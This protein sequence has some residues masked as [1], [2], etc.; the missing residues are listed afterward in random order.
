[1]K[2][3]HFAIKAISFV[4]AF[5]IALADVVYAAPIEHVGDA[6]AKHVSPS[7]A[8]LQDPA[9]FEAPLDFST[10]KEIHA[11]GKSTF[12]VHIQDAHANLSGQQNLAGALDE[13]MSKYKI[14][15]VLV[16]GGTR[17][18]SLTPIK[19]LATPDVWK[20]VAK[21]FLIEG[22]ITGE[23]YLNL[24]SDHPMKIMGIEDKAL[25]MESLNAYSALAE[26]REEALRSLKI[27]RNAAE[28]LK[29]KLYPAD[30]AEYEGLDREKFEDRFKVLAR[31]GRDPGPN[32]RKLLA[33]QERESQIDFKIANLEQAAL[34]EAISKKGG[35]EELKGL[36]AKLSKM[37][38]QKASQLNFLQ[39]LLRSAKE[40]NIPLEAYSNLFRYEAYLKDFSGIDLEALIE[41]ME[42]LEDEVYRARLTSE[43]ARLLRSIDRYLGLLDVAFRIQMS[44]KEFKTFE[45]NEPD[46]STVAYLAFLNRKLAEMGYFEDMLAAS[47]A[48]E[49]TK[50]VL[51]KFY[52]VVSRRDEAFLRNSE[53]ILKEEEQEIAVLIAGGYHTAHLR[54]LFKDKGF[55]YAVL[56]PIVRAETNQAKYEKILLEPIREEKSTVT[57]GSETPRS[58]D[59]ENDLIQLKKRSEGNRQQALVE[60]GSR[61]AE[62]IGYVSSGEEAAAVALEALTGSRLKDTGAISPEA[63]EKLRQE[64]GSRLAEETGEETFEHI[65]IQGG[66]AQ[67]A[68][69][70]KRAL[71]SIRDDNLTHPSHLR[72]VTRVIIEELE[73]GDYG[74]VRHLTPRI[75]WLDPKGLEDP[76]ALRSLLRHELAHVVEMTSIPARK[77]WKQ[78][79]IGDIPSVIRFFYKSL[80]SVFSTIG[81]SFVAYLVHLYWLMPNSY[82]AEAS[83]AVASISMVFVVSLLATAFLQPLMQIIYMTPLAPVVS[84][85]ALMSGEDFAESYMIYANSPEKFRR[86]AKF[87][88]FLKA[89]YQAVKKIHELDLEKASAST[90]SKAWNVTFDPK[91]GS[92]LAGIRKVSGPVELPDSPESR[93]RQFFGGSS[94]RLMGWLG[95]EKKNGPMLGY[96]VLPEQVTNFVFYRRIVEKHSLAFENGT[97][98]WFT[99]RY[100][101][102]IPGKF[103]LS[104]VRREALVTRRAFK[105]GLGPRAI[106]LGVQGRPVLVLMPQEGRPLVWPIDESKAAAVGRALGRLHSGGVHHGDLVGR[107]DTTSPRLD[108]IYEDEGT[109]RF[110]D[111]GEGDVRP[112]KASSLSA[113]WNRLWF[114][115]DSV[116]EA[117]FLGR[118]LGHSAIDGKAEYVLQA[119]KAAYRQFSRSASSAVP[120]RAK[121]PVKARFLTEDERDDLAA[122]Q[123]QNG[124][125]R[126][127]QEPKIDDTPVESTLIEEAALLRQPGQLESIVGVDVNGYLQFITR[128]TYDRWFGARLA[129]NLKRDGNTHAGAHFS[130]RIVRDEIL[131][132]DLVE[133]IPISPKA[134]DSVRLA[135]ENL[136][137]LAVPF[138][139]IGGAD[140]RIRMELVQ[141]LNEA[142]EERIARADM[143]SAKTLLRQFFEV[144]ID[145]IRRGIVNWDPKLEN[146]GLTK[147]GRVVL[148]DVDGLVSAESLLNQSSEELNSDDSDIFFFTTKLREGIPAVMRPHFYQFT[149]DYHL[150]NGSEIYKTIQRLAYSEKP[151]KVQAPAA[152]LAADRP[153][154]EEPSGSA[155][156]Q[157]DRLMS[158]VRRHFD[159]DTGYAYGTNS[160]DAGRGKITSFGHFRA[161][162]LATIEAAFSVIPIEG[163]TVFSLGSGQAPELAVAAAYGA[164]RAVGVEGDADLAEDAM[165]II[166]ALRREAEWADI[167][168]PIEL[169][170]GNF[171][172]DQFSFRKADII[173]YTN[174]GSFMETA[175]E[176]KLFDQ[177]KPEALLVL[178][179]APTRR[180]L[181]FFTK[182]KR[183]DIPGLPAGV[184]VYQNIGSRLAEEGDEAESGLINARDLPPAYER[185]FDGAVRIA[186]AF[187]RSGG[188]AL[189]LSGVTAPF[190]YSFFAVAW[191]RLFED[192]P[193]PLTYWIRPETE[194]FLY[195]DPVRK[196]LAGRQLDDDLAAAAVRTVERRARKETGSL[197]EALKRN[198]RDPQGFTLAEL[199]RAK[200]FFLGE[201]DTW[202]IEPK[203]YTAIFKALGFG[204]VAF[205]YH[206]AGPAFLKRL[207]SALAGIEDEKLARFMRSV[208]STLVYWDFD[209]P[210]EAEFLFEKLTEQA[211]ELLGHRELPFDLS[212][213]GDLNESEPDRDPKRF[214]AML[215]VRGYKLLRSFDRGGS[216]SSTYLAEDTQGRRV[217]IKYADWDGISGNGAPWVVRQAEKLLEIQRTFPEEARKQYPR[218]LD[219]GQ[220]KGE[221]FYAMELFE[222]AEDIT[223]Y[224]FFEPGLTQQEIAAEIDTFVTLMAET[225]YSQHLEVY[226]GEFKKHFADRLAMRLGHLSRHDGEI[227]EKLVRGRPAEA[228]GRQYKDLSYLFE[229]LLSRPWI[230]VNGRAY[231]NLPRLAA[232]LVERADE[233]E[234]R[235][236]PTHYSKYTH[237]DL[238]LRNVLRLPDGTKKIIDVRGRDIHPES[239]SQPSV[240]YD[241]AK[242]AH[243]FTLELVRNGY[244]DLRLEDREGIPSIRLHY[245][246]H[247]GNRRYLAMRHDFSGLLR[248][249]AVLGKV[250]ASASDG[251]LDYV[252]L[253][254]AVNYGSDAIHRLSQD[255]T[256]RDSL[257]Y[258]AEATVGI[259]DFL[260]RQGLLPQDW[261]LL[262][263]RQ[264]RSTHAP[265]A[266]GY[267]QIFEGSIGKEEIGGEFWVGVNG[268]GGSGKTEFTSRLVQWAKAQGRSLPR[269]WTRKTGETEFKPADPWLSFDWFLAERDVRNEV[270]RSAADGRLP[271]SR[272]RESAWDTPAFHVFL[273]NARQTSSAKGEA[274]PLSIEHA[275]NRE[276]G[277]RD[278]EVRIEFPQKA[279]IAVE[280]VDPADAQTRPIFDYVFFVDVADDRELVDRALARE[281]RKSPEKRLAPEI[282]QNRYTQVD[283][284]RAHYIRRVVAPLSDAIV[285]NTDYSQPVLYT[286]LGARLAD[287]YL[288]GPSDGRGI[289]NRFPM[290]R[291]L[292]DLAEREH[293]QVISDF[294]QGLAFVERLRK[295]DPEQADDLEQRASAVAYRRSDL[296]A[297]ASKKGLSAAELKEAFGL[298]PQYDHA[299]VLIHKD[300]WSAE[301]L[302]LEEVL[303]ILEGDN[304]RE[305]ETP[306]VRRQARETVSDFMVLMFYPWMALFSFESNYVRWTGLQKR[307]L[308]M[309]YR[310]IPKLDPNTDMAAMLRLLKTDIEKGRVLTVGGE[311]IP[312][313]SLFTNKSEEVRRELVPYL[314]GLLESQKFDQQSPL[315]P[316]MANG[317]RLGASDSGEVRV[318]GPDQLREW[319]ERDSYLLGLLGKGNNSF[320]AYEF[321]DE[322]HPLAGYTV[323]VP[324]SMDPRIR[325]EAD[326]AKEWMGGL[327]PPFTIVEN[328][329]IR[330][331]KYP[332]VVVAKKLFSF[333]GSTSSLADTAEEEGSFPELDLQAMERELLVEFVRRGIYYSDALIAKNYG[334]DLETKRLHFI[335]FGGSKKRS[336]EW[337]FGELEEPSQHPRREKGILQFDKTNIDLYARYFDRIGVPS[338]S[339]LYELW[340]TDAKPYPVS[341]PRIPNGARLANENEDGDRKI[342]GPA[343]KPVVNDNGNGSPTLSGSARSARYFPKRLFRKKV[344]ELELA[345]ALAVIPNAIF[346]RSFPDEELRRRIEGPLREKERMVLERQLGR[347]SNN[348]VFLAHHEGTGRRYVISVHNPNQVHL[349]ALTEEDM[350]GRVQRS[351]KMVGGLPGMN[352]EQPHRSIRS[353]Y[354]FNQIDGIPYA[355][356]NYIE[357]SDIETVNVVNALRAADQASIAF[358]LFT[359]PLQLIAALVYLAEHRIIMEREVHARNVLVD[360]SQD[361]SVIDYD[362]ASKNWYSPA[363]F[364][365]ISI[366]LHRTAATLISYLLDNSYLKFWQH[367]DAKNP[368]ELEKGMMGEYKTAGL[369]E[370]GGDVLPKAAGELSRI[371]RKML[372]DPADGQYQ[373][374]K[375]VFIDLARIT[376]DLMG[377]PFRD[378]AADLPAQIKELFEKD[379]AVHPNGTIATVML[380]GGEIG[381]LHPVIKRRIFERFREEGFEVFEGAITHLS[382]SQA[383]QRWGGGPFFST[384]KQLEGHIP[385]DLF[386]RVVEAGERGDS[387]R[388]LS[389]IAHIHRYLRH[390][391]IGAEANT[392]L[393][394]IDS[395]LDYVM[396]DSQQLLLRY[397]RPEPLPMDVQDYVKRLVGRTVDPE[398]ESLRGE[399]LIPALEPGQ[400]LE[401]VL[402]EMKATYPDLSREEIRTTLNGIHTPKKEELDLEFSVMTA[403]DASL[404]I[405]SILRWNDAQRG[406]TA[407]EGS[408]LA[409][410]TSG[411]TQVHQFVDKVSAWKGRWARYLVW[412]RPLTHGLIMISSFGFLA[413][414]HSDYFMH[415]G[416]S[417]E[418]AMQSALGIGLPTVMEW[419]GGLLALSPVADFLSKKNGAQS[420][421]RWQHALSAAGVVVK[422]AAKIFRALAPWASLPARILRATIEVYRDPKNSSPFV[423]AGLAALAAGAYW[424]PHTF[425]Y[426]AAFEQTSWAAAALFLQG[427]SSAVLFR[428]SWPSSSGARLAGEGGIP[429]RVFV[430]TMLGLLGAAGAAAGAYQWQKQWIRPLEEG[431]I[432]S[433]DMDD[434]IFEVVSYDAGLQILPANASRTVVSNLN[435]YSKNLSGAKTP[436]GLLIEQGFITNPFNPNRLLKG[437][438]RSQSAM[439]KVIVLIKNNKVRFYR[440]QDM[441]LEKIEAEQAD[442]GFQAGP[443]AVWDGVINENIWEWHQNSAGR[444]RVL[445]ADAEGNLHTRE[446]YGRDYLGYTS[447]PLEEFRNKF[448]AWATE[449]RIQN[450]IFV[451]AGSVGLHPADDRPTHVLV[452]RT[453]NGARLAAGFDETLT[454]LLERFSK[455]DRPEE[456]TKLIESVYLK[457]RR[458][459]KYDP[460]I[461]TEIQR[462][463]QLMEWGASTEAIAS[464]VLY[465]AFDVDQRGIRR[466]LNE[467]SRPG[468][469]VVD[470]ERTRKIQGYLDRVLAA[471]RIPFE[472][473]IFDSIHERGRTYPNFTNMITV[474]TQD[475]DTFLLLAGIKQGAFILTGAA[476]TISDRD[477]RI[478]ELKLYRTLASWRGAQDVAQTLDETILLMSDPQRYGELEK[479]VRKALGG[480]DRHEVLSWLQELE[481]TLSDHLEKQGIKASIRFR[482]KS[483][484]SISDKKARIPVSKMKD[485]LGIQVAAENMA[486]AEKVVLAWMGYKDVLP[487]NVDIQMAQPGVGFQ[488]QK[489][490]K[491]RHI[492]L[493]V[494]FPLTASRI[495]L[496][497]QVMTPR[498]LEAYWRGLD[499]VPSHPW[500]KLTKWLSKILYH[501]KELKPRPLGPLSPDPAENFLRHRTQMDDRAYVA[502]YRPDPSKN[503]I[504]MSVAELADGSHPTDLALRLH[505]E[506]GEAFKGFARLKDA[507]LYRSPELS[508]DPDHY[509][510]LGADYEFRTGDIVFPVQELPLDLQEALSAEFGAFFS[511]TKARMLSSQYYLSAWSDPVSQNFW[512]EEGEALV[513]GGRKGRLAEEQ[514]D[515]YLDAFA[516]VAAFDE[517]EDLYGA[518]GSGLYGV[519]RFWKE[520][521][522]YA[523]SEEQVLPS[524]FAQDRKSDAGA[525]LANSS[526]FG[527]I[528]NAVDS[529]LEFNGSIP[530]R[531]RRDYFDARNPRPQVMLGAFAEKPLI[532]RDSSAPATDHVRVWNAPDLSQV[533]KQ[534]YDK[535]LTLALSRLPSGRPAYNERERRFILR[536]FTLAFI[537]HQFFPKKADPSKGKSKDNRVLRVAEGTTPY[538]IH[539][540]NVATSLFYEFGKFLSKGRKIS[541]TAIAAALLHDTLEDTTLGEMEAGDL[542][543]LLPDSDG[544][545]AWKM[546]Q[547][548]TKNKAETGSDYLEKIRNSARTEGDDFLRYYDETLLIKLADKLAS[549]RIDLDLVPNADLNLKLSKNIVDFLNSRREFAKHFANFPYR[550][551]NKELQQA[552]LYFNEQYLAIRNAQRTRI[553]EKYGVPFV[554]KRDTQR[555]SSVHVR[556]TDPSTGT[557]HARVSGRETEYRVMGLSQ[558]PADRSEKAFD[559][560]WNIVRNAMLPLWPREFLRDKETTRA[561][562]S[563]E[564]TRL[565]AVLIFGESGEV[566]GGYLVNKEFG[567]LDAIAV[568]NGKRGSGAT[569]VLIAHLKKYYLQG[570]DTMNLLTLPT[571]LRD[572]RDPASGALIVPVDQIEEKLGVSRV[573]DETAAVPG[574]GSRLSQAAET[575]EKLEANLDKF[576]LN[577]DKR[578]KRRRPDERAFK[579]FLSEWERWTQEEI[580]LF[581]DLRGAMDGQPDRLRYLSAHFGDI[582]DKATIYAEKS[583]ADLV[584]RAR[585]LRLRRIAWGNLGDVRYALD[586]DSQ[587]AIDAYLEALNMEIIPGYPTHRNRQEIRQVIRRLGPLWIAIF[588][589]P[590][591]G[592]LDRG[593]SG[594]DTWTVG[595]HTLLLLA[596]LPYLIEKEG[597]FHNGDF[598]AMAERVALHDV[599]EIITGDITPV[600]EGRWKNKTEI[601]SRAREELLGLLDRYRSQTVDISRWQRKLEK[602]ESQR[603][604]KSRY[605]KQADKVASQVELL[606]QAERFPA[607]I[608]KF[609]EPFENP[610]FHQWVDYKKLVKFKSL[611]DFYDELESLRRRIYE[612]A[613][614]RK[615]ALKDSKASADG[616]RLA[617]VPYGFEDAQAKVEAM[618]IHE[619][620]TPLVSELR[621][622]IEAWKPGVPAQDE[623]APVLAVIQSIR[624]K[625]G[626][627]PW[628]VSR[629]LI[630]RTLKSGYRGDNPYNLMEFIERM[631]MIAVTDGY[632]VSDEALD[633]VRSDLGR[634]EKIAELL[635]DYSR[636]EAPTEFRTQ[637][638]ITFID[639]EA[640]VGVGSRLSAK[641]EDLTQSERFVAE[642][643]DNSTETQRRAAVV[644]LIDRLVREEFGGR[645]EVT[646]EPFKADGAPHF[647]LYF[648]WGPVQLSD[649]RQ[650]SRVDF[651]DEYHLP[652]RYAAGD[653]QYVPSE[654]RLILV[655]EDSIDKSYFYGNG[656]PAFL[657]LL[658]GNE[659][660]GPRSG[661]WRRTAA[662]GDAE[663][664]GWK[665]GRKGYEDTIKDIHPAVFRLLD[666]TV[667]EIRSRSGATGLIRVADLFS[668]DGSFAGSV[669]RSY[670]EDAVEVMAVERNEELLRKAV[671]EH[672]E[673]AGNF[674]RA[675]LTQTQEL[676]SLVGRPD[677]VTI[678]GGLNAQVIKRAD[679]LGLARQVF[680]A[681]NDGGYLIVAGYTQTLLYR[682]DFAGLGFEVLNMSVPGNMRPQ[683]VKAP[684]D[685][686]VLRKPVGARLADRLFLGSAVQG[687][688]ISPRDR[689]LIQRIFSEN[690]DFVRSS[691]ETVHGKVLDLDSPDLRV[692]VTFYSDEGY[693]KNVYRVH[694]DGV[695]ISPGQKDLALKLV[696]P[697]AERSR[698][699]I[700]FDQA[701]LEEIWKIAQRLHEHD[702]ALFPALGGYHWMDDGAE[703][704]LAYL[705]EF[706]PGPTLDAVLKNEESDP[707]QKA[708]AARHAVRSYV[709]A[710]DL[711]ERTRFILDPT[712]KNIKQGEQGNWKL[713]DLDLLGPLNELRPQEEIIRHTN[714][715]AFLFYLLD[716][717]IRFPSGYERYLFD[718]IRDALKP[719]EWREVFVA[720][721]QGMV[722]EYEDTMIK[723]IDR[724]LISEHQDYQPD[725]FESGVGS[726]LAEGGVP[727]LS[728]IY[729]A[730]LR[731]Q[732]VPVVV[733]EFPVLT[734]AAF[735]PWFTQHPG[736]ELPILADRGIMRLV[737]QDVRGIDVSSI[738]RQTI[739]SE[740]SI[741]TA[742]PSAS[743]L[744]SGDLRTLASEEFRQARVFDQEIV[745]LLT[746]KGVPDRALS[747][748]LEI[749]LDQLAEKGARLATPTFTRNLKVLLLTLSLIRGQAAMQDVQF[750][751]YGT[752]AL[753]EHALDK[754]LSQYQ[755][756]PTQRM[757]TDQRV[758]LTNPDDLKEGTGYVALANAAPDAHYPV[759][760][761]V[762]Y[763]LYELAVKNVGEKRMTPAD[764]SDRVLQEVQRLAGNPVEADKL[765]KEHVFGFAQGKLTQEL[766]R[767]AVAYLI[768]PLGKLLDADFSDFMQ[769]LQSLG[770]AA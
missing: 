307:A 688:S 246:D 9:K 444:K 370:K 740:R 678:I 659:L 345:R 526:A 90:P 663:W 245:Y 47:P 523:R 374:T 383:V 506:E 199:K 676:M 156:A 378:S 476:D 33:I 543:A 202:A 58:S 597:G 52:G 470:R 732:I 294:G 293:T 129:A 150:S 626:G 126:V 59:L 371:L 742:E 381:G 305:P 173:L 81:V 558:V 385:Q 665:P 445:G 611:A 196:F 622:L 140:P 204:P 592:G 55:S 217:I 117:Y 399:I 433:F 178:F 668:G 54:Q 440:T 609:I 733:G 500:Y 258:Y 486:E 302:L 39:S 648:P 314:E 580:S 564:E 615:S 111:F 533:Y 336:R 749:N 539:P 607:L 298:D 73:G 34:V 334:I 584:S 158:A 751:F 723:Q 24:T 508:D 528:S 417:W 3:H 599:V 312:V 115:I 468:R 759:R 357:G 376:A 767:M 153:D 403:A 746:A 687:K 519:E 396:R 125:L 84:E 188:N 520:F 186:H 617:A 644:Q 132:E 636:S 752:P 430:R 273:A 613:I 424:F 280:G 513:R 185:M 325:E 285:D 341:E 656:R 467:L 554:Q 91:N 662:L 151:V 61:L 263:D 77:I 290:M 671:A 568:A 395:M 306:W 618:K 142:I 573:I 495:H 736:D 544:Q 348:V 725:V 323:K 761:I 364:Q 699:P 63:P 379:R 488:D 269:V 295:I 4:L 212:L 68:A 728:R 309:E 247:P 502:V 193:L 660:D 595:D 137:G 471:D 619:A 253:G 640:T 738:R 703:R 190:V 633:E 223:N 669:R 754:G 405:W 226:P 339:Q 423:M 113:L 179:Y 152:W 690:G 57:S 278:L 588:Y 464:A 696:K 505:L 524:L 709:R 492:D 209:E 310:E 686:Y 436:I 737:A 234:R 250:F 353:V 435:P 80:A 62:V 469:A 387:R 350:R 14:S 548:L 569:H 731:T 174:S 594:E 208:S 494:R 7:Q 411:A 141:T 112:I 267:P 645:V 596:L 404:F 576:D 674:I 537:A 105:I 684:Q 66:T 629:T 489:A 510:L 747:G 324:V 739:L 655:W 408:R 276:T 680:D 646:E 23:E 228:M 675:D 401:G 421:P 448:S 579:A 398:P 1:M 268:P 289:V 635:A 499:Q 722:P 428:S 434:F 145:I 587:G 210:G 159:V 480:A 458:S 251:W 769:A 138:R 243:S 338:D 219:S 340:G 139:I 56:A 164:G 730:S 317:S 187:R 177:M 349:E 485:L 15:L 372:A 697:L 10:L 160:R 466:S 168:K 748:V 114:R 386:K 291:D 146:Y 450:A 540:V 362:D 755:M 8:L 65:R 654:K 215:A 36:A 71:E 296:E 545:M 359:V 414:A 439:Q 354:H 453:K 612:Q 344:T 107:I 119:F 365:L 529:L 447:L 416:I 753:V 460:R 527:D 756:D 462:A 766:R 147:D 438:P 630:E 356:F 148:I 377:S 691:Y 21:K 498:M 426:S 169:Y 420:P 135:H 320:A 652:L 106:V 167:T 89:R 750:Y 517:T 29:H 427:T 536:A 346:H 679:A 726:R 175:L 133:K 50:A 457:L 198:L 605:V 101:G 608:E 621:Q 465:A 165:E 104:A 86:A 256:G 616:S 422:G 670:P 606:A 643:A 216:A 154:L 236:G 720:A 560:Y 432:R 578:M 260:E 504:R 717:E 402:E 83:S 128:T 535:I 562:V 206:V 702:P 711:A 51:K 95:Y 53:R 76:D 542:E 765:Q 449:H 400:P 373:N 49:E 41:E 602:Y 43:D 503:V 745:K 531:I 240:E 706:E 598:L 491:G 585:I 313:E 22:K 628:T 413:A 705:V 241:L 389:G 481:L 532:F 770:Q 352:W 410:G 603:D 512:R 218:V 120:V 121:G 85:Y 255:P 557:W 265:A 764:I 311:S 511:R 118:A 658:K 509:E 623:R 541:A 257:A 48:L 712:A 664:D 760:P 184:E 547:V 92:R 301:R 493:R 192:V 704:T 563:R 455:L 44:T 238:P 32:S 286:D 180:L 181:P 375:Q 487:D 693:H 13:L 641:G 222:D 157:R 25:Y 698:S 390:N 264:F 474:M 639:L 27:V 330:G 593:L 333:H 718:G 741:M 724:Y 559:E 714:L 454:T 110:I 574:Q 343:D 394:R 757:S 266:A 358:T 331:V 409:Q 214:P 30:L 347:G 384:V 279:F 172:S 625:I 518:I 122:W 459:K 194:A 103:S 75:I 768:R 614:L 321:D 685:L 303:H 700:R 538:I 282:I 351:A 734:Q 227:Y 197:D 316:S 590:R 244:Y 26:K 261:T 74:Q 130:S 393:H 299:V 328:V 601:E 170:Q 418:S 230:L 575:L 727:V 556:L 12:I 496:E 638:G 288:N 661:F 281:L 583:G 694:F 582:T 571:S 452:A 70:V 176:N 437:A 213:P 355:V 673:M 28:K 64:Q 525:R 249:N 149:S 363:S 96:Q 567:T 109:I 715:T 729:G 211:M 203:A 521:D 131:G 397:T 561:L 407:A 108:H 429:R 391:E 123:I 45:A 443:E 136:G 677:V 716:T 277:R 649:G 6:W 610:D 515:R 577:L 589:V 195:L 713:L 600:D 482:L 490:T 425:I 162:P 514:L 127:N 744:L 287:L 97:L 72:R 461:L 201:D 572:V 586:R 522:A 60:N 483:L 318:A 2:R 67:E 484:S 144:N 360:D 11:G 326:F 297:L 631:G 369:L 88:P 735:V 475:H 272:Y 292:T 37:K 231:P 632:P 637:G 20:R 155:I 35:R 69:A 274:A 308:A 534:A 627:Y 473:E 651:Y 78:E 124:G 620:I 233:I 507:V 248:N 412:A 171:L 93:F 672:P 653:A 191:V 262:L 337:A 239:P 319:I 549:F 478:V 442:Y 463:M 102:W 220:N 315:F 451:D 224:F 566:I 99:K 719:E 419:V 553:A 647:S 40:K 242:I 5:K 16:E 657:S 200:V 134:M 254:E 707:A 329:T 406:R 342:E 456:D 322:R 666:E 284:P 98:E 565:D 604:V 259:W 591:G 270:V 100:E 283:L 252:R 116:M 683:S 634:I 380:K 366:E 701:R 42:R 229:D 143:E 552:A 166:G 758:R 446:F 743:A 189:I 695:G 708:S 332:F 207:P 94:D 38:D 221:A 163:K 681:L 721:R 692:Y 18:D 335:D 763:G 82:P 472:P 555:P 667:Q 183:I 182:L 441:T 205:A 300:D 710:W 225:H 19:K 17:D 477:P 581:L 516:H 689:A 382:L 551:E 237:G 642:A 327:V 392:A 650:L 682:D 546:V 87:N 235:L 762:H 388:F 275:Y 570:K 550:T 161:T 304:Q 624:S 367:W 431:S 361:V 415:R 497:V 530:E 501:E 232:L 271:L 368:G 46:F 31:L 479:E 79:G